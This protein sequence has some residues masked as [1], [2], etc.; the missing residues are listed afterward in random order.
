VPEHEDCADIGKKELA[1]SAARTISCWVDKT[2]TKPR[3]LQICQKTQ[4][5]DNIA[6]HP[7]WGRKK[8]RS[9]VIV[10]VSGPSTA[11]TGKGRLPNER[12]TVRTET[13]CH[14]RS[15]YEPKNHQKR[16][17]RRYQPAGGTGRYLRGGRAGKGKPKGG[18]VAN[19]K[20]RSEGD[21][22]AGRRAVAGKK[23]GKEKRKANTKAHGKKLEGAAK[24]RSASTSE[25]QGFAPGTKKKKK[26][27]SKKW[28]EK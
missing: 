24:N 6:P 10:T 14:Q 20:R 21:L 2:K 16:K 13:G 27:A 26:T 4:S 19:L 28:W 25:V 9:R 12:K 15:Y 7:L 3:I 22:L 17:G 23:N 1:G 5:S 8:A 11:G 18:G